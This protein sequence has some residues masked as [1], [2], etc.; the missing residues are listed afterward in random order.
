[1]VMV[2]GEATPAVGLDR[3][4]ASAAAPLVPATIE[5]HR[6]RL[7]LLDVQGG[8]IA[9]LDDGPRDGEVIVLVHGMPTSSW[10]WRKVVPGLVHAGFRVVAPD[11]LGFGAS[12]KPAHALLYEIPRQAARLGELLD[13]LGV[14]R[15]TFAVH[16]LGGPWAFELADRAPERFAR[17]VILNTVAYRDGVQPPMMVR[18]AGGPLGPL[19]LRMMGTSLGRPML[20][21][22]FRSF[23]GD[24][25]SMTAE[26]V[27]GYWL[28]LHEGTTRPFRQFART[29]KYTF[30]N[31][32]RWAAALR[33]LGVP[34]LVIWGALDQVLDGSKQ[35]R[36]FARDLAIP[37][38]RIHLISDANHFLQEDH[39]PEVAERISA[40][41]RQQAAAWR[42]PNGLH[43]SR[44]TRLARL[45]R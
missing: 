11:L 32:D 16:D 29:F 44:P 13:A 28:P 33:R 2:T 31:L 4:V 23:V 26:A 19:M 15:A 6:A 36:L 5:A 7:H 1:M 40:F 8:R 37:D 42:T 14:G 12:D 38:D 22:S 43:E 35:S 9:Y 45:P 3:A 27:R 30:G 10:V 21:F 25:S 39:G 17:L 18:M 24:P 20:A 34:A 41:M